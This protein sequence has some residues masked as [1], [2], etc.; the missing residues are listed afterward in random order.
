MKLKIEIEI[1]DGRYCFD[2]ENKIEECK[3]LRSQFCDIFRKVCPYYKGKVWKCS[4][5]FN[6]SL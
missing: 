1:P 2:K 5:C 3:F 6:E 4:E